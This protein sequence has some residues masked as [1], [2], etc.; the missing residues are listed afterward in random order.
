VPI[1]S[2]DDQEVVGTIDIESEQSD[3][4]SADVERTLVACADVI[5]PLWD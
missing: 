3:A 5:Q 2:C 4:F 1:F